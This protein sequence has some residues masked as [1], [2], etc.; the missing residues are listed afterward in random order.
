M[1]EWATSDP[2]TGCLDVERPSGLRT[3]PEP[4]QQ[5]SS[6]KRS[7]LGDLSGRNSS[8]SMG[9]RKR[10]SIVYRRYERMR[11]SPIIQLVFFAEIL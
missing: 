10:S 11:N 6:R 5:R 8:I 3:P 7:S 9:F 1:F 2:M 4:Q